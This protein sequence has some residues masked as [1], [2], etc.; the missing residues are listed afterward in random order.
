MAVDFRKYFAAAEETASGGKI[1]TERMVQQTNRHRPGLR[2]RR[3]PDAGHA[4]AVD[5]LLQKVRAE[6]A[7]AAQFGIVGS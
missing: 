1:E 5:Q 7:G 2:V 4:A 6:L 3:Q